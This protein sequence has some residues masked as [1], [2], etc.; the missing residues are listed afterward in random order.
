MVAT[1]VCRTHLLQPLSLAAD[2]V[3]GRSGTGLVAAVGAADLSV[4]LSGRVCLRN[5]EL[6]PDPKAADPHRPKVAHPNGG[7]EGLNETPAQV[8]TPNVPIPEGAL[9]VSQV[10]ARPKSDRDPPCGRVP[11]SRRLFRGQEPGRPNPPEL[12]PL[13][14]IACARNPEKI[15]FQAEAVR[16]IVS[17]VCA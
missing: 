14:P 4:E 15:R 9:A 2:V 10:K 13:G 1:A 5:S 17:V 16:P 3:C 8:P 12:R 6:L 11:Q 7:T